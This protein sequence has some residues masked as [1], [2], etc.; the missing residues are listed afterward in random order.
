[1]VKPH[2]VQQA[3]RPHV[4]EDSLRHAA[5]ERLMSDRHMSEMT[6]QRRPQ[7]QVQDGLRPVEHRIEI[8]KTVIDLCAYFIVK[9]PT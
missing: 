8:D 1:M 4:R 6:V 7:N 9:Y 3:E 5:G 2:V